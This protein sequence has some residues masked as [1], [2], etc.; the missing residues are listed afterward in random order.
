MSSKRKSERIAKRISFSKFVNDERNPIDVD[1][2]EESNRMSEGNV[3]N[4]SATKKVLKGQRSPVAK[5]P[6]GMY[7]S[8]EMHVDYFVSCIYFYGCSLTFV[9]NGR[10]S[11][12]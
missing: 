10:R 5:K 7:I 2:E 3:E 9:Y 8:Y 6:R 11:S 4:V 1:M 12:R